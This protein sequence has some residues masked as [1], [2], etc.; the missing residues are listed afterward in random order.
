MKR[1]IYSL[2][3]CAGLAVTS[4][5][6]AA[7]SVVRKVAETFDDST[8]RASQYNR[9]TGTS[10]SDTQK[11]PDARSSGSQRWD[12]KFSGKGFEWY[13]IEPKE[14]LW[15]P[16]NA[17]SVT[18]RAKMSD[19]RC[20]LRLTFV[21]GWGRERSDGKG[22]E[23]DL[24]PAADGQ[25][26]TLTAKIPDEWVRP[27]RLVG[28]NT[29]NWDTQNTASTLQLWLDDLEIETDLS[30]VDLR[31]GVLKSWKPEPNPADP[32]KA[33]KEPPATPLLLTSIAAS[34][35]FNVFAGVQPRFR[36]SI[37]SW[38]PEPVTGE[39]QWK[40]L[41]S[42]SG[43][44]ASGSTP[45]RVE[46]VQSIEV[47]P[48]INR[49]GLY[50]IELSGTLSDG[51]TLAKSEPLA[52]IPKP[53]E[54]SEE[55]K[56]KSP[57]GLNVHS[58]R[59]QMVSTFR[60]AGI[61]WFRDYA[62]GMDTMMAAKGPD[63]SYSGWP[64]YPQIVR[65]FE[66]NGARVLACLRRGIKPPREDGTIGPDAE[67][68][69]EMASI[70]MAF[71]YVRHYELDNE[72]DLGNHG[73][74]SK[75]IP[76]GWANYR[77][78]HK[79]FGDIVELFGAGNYVAVENGRAGVYPRRVTA[80]V[81]SGDFDKIQVVN[82]HHYTG[83]DAPE[84]NVANHNVGVNS[85]EEMMLFF[86]QLRYA[87]RGGRADGTPREHW[88]TEFGWD[89]LA[90][91]VVTPY[92]QAIYLSRGYMMAMA[93]GCEKAF[94]FFDLDAE[95]PV[96]FFDGCGLVTHQQLPKLSLCAYAGLTQILPRPEFVGMI[97][98]GEGTWGY[99][100][101][102]DGQLVASLFTIDAEKGPSIDFGSAKLY[103]YLANPI[104]GS[105][106]T[107]TTAPVFAVG[108]SK[109]SLWFKQSAYML[110]TPYLVGACAGD[111]VNAQLEVKNER[112]T[113]IRGSVDLKLPAGWSVVGTLPTINVAPG[114]TALVPFSF[115]VG[116]QETVGEQRVL[117]A[118]AE[119][120]PIVTI[121][122][123]V[124]T[125]E[126]IEMVVRGLG[127]EPGEDTV[128]VTITNR[129]AKPLDGALELMLP[130]TWKAENARITV[131]T[132]AAGET[133]EIPCKLTWSETWAASESAYI[134]F[135]TS[136][137][138]SAQ[139][140]LIPS[141]ISIR[142]A[143]D[144]K[145]D[146]DLGDWDQSMRIPSW[147]LGSTIGKA[148][149]ELYMAWSEK[150][151]YVAA[152]VADSK[153]NTPDPR[154]FWGGDC[155]ELFIDT[156]NKKTARQYEVGDHQ[157]WF[158]PQVDD[159][160]VYVGQWK[161]GSELAETRYD[162]PGFLTAAARTDDGYVMEFL[163]PASELKG[164]EARSGAKLGLSLN[165]SVKGKEVLE[166]EVFWRLPKRETTEHPESWGSVTLTD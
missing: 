18:L 19:S 112:E 5:S 108:V 136:D 53:I 119:D 22:H 25:W 76:I 105:N 118:I 151:L 133:R 7:E 92:Q 102:N 116:P 121:P 73:D 137:G 31:T 39:I 29:H 12:I 10:A 43:Q 161:R 165:L 90:G 68:R 132:L 26:G 164:F 128:T 15:I 100:F 58:G 47:A 110:H 69:R 113:P 154:S 91:Q 127:G 96:Q 89:T 93:A 103:D 74:S 142:R 9:A 36:V 159:K 67:W 123:R 82:S 80:C 99:L 71:P 16:G 45:V 63:R 143:G 120:Q 32:A 104:E 139:Q 124:V 81:E 83:V 155:L 60:S 117:I 24:K 149:A 14:Q 40:L 23:I 50:G 70:V 86:D 141:R 30:D 38:L 27:I 126:P 147:V 156:R 54:L 66:E 131:E 11:A 35:D 37:R 59:A 106:V 87:K 138:R 129:S 56:D 150:G 78:Y 122:L 28:I 1:A 13:T 79:V 3:L 140:P 65:T 111:E 146:A 52:Y 64:W 107:L 84:V 109:D 42:S 144:L 98:A 88:L 51:T 153:I 61:T 114:E 4:V 85:D 166:R 21:D 158:V 44:L 46:D 34:R 57:Y 41:D 72:Y 101:R 145:I 115:R 157:F 134:R 75:E 130:S 20:A 33:F 135:I 97:S 55:E 17:K 77:A 125:R 6:L 2:G 148:N 48:E 95:K 94:W 163:I 62:F 152:N 8:W 162:I 49:Y 160:R